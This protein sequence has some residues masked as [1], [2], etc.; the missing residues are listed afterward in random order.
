[1]TIART[2]EKRFKQLRSLAS[3]W[4]SRF[5][6]ERFIFISG[7]HHSGTTLVQEVL[8]QQG[9]FMFVDER[10]DGEPG[11]PQ[12]T[13]LREL[14]RLRREAWQG[15][16]AWA[17]MKFPSNTT[18]AVGRLT[19]ELPLLAP[20][21]ALVLCYRDPAATVLSL[22]GRHGWD[23]DRA[24][25]DAAAQQAV[26]DAWQAYTDGHRGRV[27][28]LALEDFTADPESYVRAILGLRM[29]QALPTAIGD[30]KRD[31]GEELPELP[32]SASHE[33]RRRIQTRLPIYPV[34]RDDWQD[35]ATDAAVLEVL[36]AIRERYGTSPVFPP[37]N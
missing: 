27:V 10:D 7:F 18:E 17:A 14:H 29:D 8:R 35:T 15:G 23:P 19:R 33:D 28:R 21:C 2:V 26:A 5:P 24:W 37:T 1:M 25:R 34:G 6:D 36:H 22:A 12:E 32:D 31:Q 3:R 4:T 16:H 20:R 9:A 13:H 30:R 11:R